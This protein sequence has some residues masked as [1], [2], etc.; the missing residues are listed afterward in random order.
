MYGDLTAKKSSV[1]STYT[2]SKTRQNCGII[3]S[4]K[5]RVL[6]KTFSIFF[7]S[8]KKKTTQKQKHKTNKKPASH[9]I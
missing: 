6:P 7:I 5:F 3:Q 8:V 9:N 4:M 2:W 1:S